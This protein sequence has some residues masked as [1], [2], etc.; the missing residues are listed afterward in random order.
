MENADR[1]CNGIEINGNAAIII[2]R[3]KILLFWNRISRGSV[4]FR[5]AP[6]VTFINM[7]INAAD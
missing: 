7:Q 4:A 2:V 6:T 3:C 1:A 5:D